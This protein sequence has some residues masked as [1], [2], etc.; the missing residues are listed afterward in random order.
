VASKIEGPARKEV[1]FR[2]AQR[3][4]LW[5]F[6]SMLPLWT[7]VGFDPSTGQFVEALDP[8]RRPTK[9]P[10]RTLVQARQILVCC[11][12]GRLGW[13]G[14][15]ADRAAAASDALV[16]HGRRDGG[17][18]IYSFDIAGRAF[19]VRSDL[20]TQAFVILGLA[21]A[22]QTL[23]RD[24]LVAEAVKTRRRLAS[25]WRDPRGGYREGEIAPHSGRQNPHMH[26][27]EA[28]LALHAVTGKDEDLEAAVAIAVLM[29][30]KLVA[31][32]DRVPEA[33]DGDWRPLQEEGAAPGHQFEWAWL[34]DRL[35]RAGGGERSGLAQA[36]ASFGE[37]HGVDADGFAVDA[38][39]LDG[40]PLAQSARLWPQAERLKTALAGLGPAPDRAAAQASRAL[41]AYLDAP[42]SGAWLDQRR[43]DGAFEFG[44]S[45]ASSAYHI[46]GALEALIAVDRLLLP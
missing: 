31:G 36:L 38:I 35:R 34:L 42:V 20:Y 26:L 27:L 11:I 14:P 40:A 25:A 23:G 5:L 39:R 16:R 41:A 13:P 19:D 45:P 37:R 29:E 21:T 3:T 15:W 18:W 10:R 44:P 9:G 17:D 7:S 32:G 2:N 46:V 43:A 6:D 12:A 4:R 33:F 8:D 1:S 28:F 22:G 30:R 24:D